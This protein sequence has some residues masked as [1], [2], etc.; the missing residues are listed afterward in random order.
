MSE[1]HKCSYQGQQ[2]A[3]IEYII[4]YE[5]EGASREDDQTLVDRPAFYEV[6]VVCDAPYFPE[7]VAARLLAAPASPSP[8]NEHVPV[9]SSQCYYSGRGVPGRQTGMVFKFMLS[10]LFN[11]DQVPMAQL[12]FNAAFA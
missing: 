3:S 10:E 7:G 4:Y 6:P 8:A 2:L 1:V 12:R 5:P 9:L 11:V